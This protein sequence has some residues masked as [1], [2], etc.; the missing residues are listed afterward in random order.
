[1][2]IKKLRLRFSSP[3]GA[4]SVDGEF[5]EP[6][7]GPV[8]FDGGKIKETLPVLFALGQVV[9]AA[10]EEGLVDVHGLRNAEIDV[11]QFGRRPLP[12]G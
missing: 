2:N 6:R 3:G 1:M 11:G 9:E 4:R 10:R 5:L 7:G 8:L 12:V